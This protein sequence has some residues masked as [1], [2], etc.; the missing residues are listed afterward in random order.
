MNEFERTALVSAWRQ[1]LTAEDGSAHRLAEWIDA[2]AD[3]LAADPFDAS[4]GAAVGGALARAHRSGCAASA[5]ILYRLGAHCPRPDAPER[6]AAILAEFGRGY[7]AQIDR[8]PC[9]RAGSEPTRRAVG[10]QPMVR[11]EPTQWVESDPMQWAGD[12]RFRIVFDNAALA[13]AISDTNG[14]LLEANRGLA[15][16]IGVPVESLRGI[17]VYEF[18]HPDDRAEIRALVYDKLVPRGQGT[19]KLDRRMVRADGSVG[20]TSFAITF[21]KGV[22]GRRDYLL[23]VG[24]DVTERRRLQDELHRQARHDPLTGLPNRRHLLERI[25]TTID[26]ARGDDQ[27][28]LCFADLDRFKQ[29]NDHFGHGVGD[30]VL[31]AVATRLHE[32]V[33]GHD[34]LVA[35]IGGDEFVALIP[36]PADDHRVTT[37]AHRLRAALTDPIVIGEHHLRVSASIGTVR[38][39][40]SGAHA[41]SLLDAADTELYRAKAHTHTHL[42]SN[43]R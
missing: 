13:I 20:W 7:Q 37:I 17:S 9:A 31:T 30:R 21:V 5:R 43:H 10:S 11:S 12:A 42:L 25:A 29:V 40:V 2:L 33:R 8:T 34:C 35:R 1:V 3:A 23:A 6:V 38:T 36:P 15:E 18:A 16:M 41:E 32:S 19:L 22:D 28:G 27:I 14:V 4:V 24:E 39:E 26:T